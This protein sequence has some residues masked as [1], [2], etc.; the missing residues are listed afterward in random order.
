MLDNDAY[1]S[2][3]DYANDT[4][5]KAMLK[6]DAQLID[7]KK[8]SI[9]DLKAKIAELQALVGEPA[10]APEPDKNAPPH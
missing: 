5:G 4:A 7:D 1:Y 10:A 9:D 2:K 8:H 6:D 3:A